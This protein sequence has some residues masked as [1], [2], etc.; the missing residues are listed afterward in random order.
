KVAGGDEHPGLGALLDQLVHRRHHLGRGRRGVRVWWVGLVDKEF[1][2]GFFL[3]QAAV[4]CCCAAAAKS[5][6]NI[7]GQ[8]SVV[9]SPTMSRKLLAQPMASSSDLTLI[10]AQPPIS[11]L[12]STNGPSVTVY[13]PAVRLTWM[14]W[15]W[16]APVAMSTPALV[17]SSIRLS[18][19]V[20]S[21]GVGG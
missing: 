12:A 14:G 13:L 18:M 2:A 17:L 15:H 7:T 5:S 8:I 1:H 6:G 20:Y 4:C 3:G 11:S 10:T 9:P 21:S 16:K 19:A